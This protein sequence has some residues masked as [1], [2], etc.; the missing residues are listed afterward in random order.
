MKIIIEIPEE[1]NDLKEEILQKISGERPHD[2]I[3][4]AVS[5]NGTINPSVIPTGDDLTSKDEIARGALS[6]LLQILLPY[7]G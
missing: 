1:K 6:Q 5:P 7:Q 4:F 2:E 3:H